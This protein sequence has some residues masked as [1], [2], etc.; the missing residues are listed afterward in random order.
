MA[1]K[2]SEIYSSLWASCDELRGDL[3]DITAHLLGGIPAAD[4]DDLSRYW[5]E[6]AGL[7]DKLFCP[8]ISRIDAKTI[9]ENHLRKFAKIRGPLPTE[10]RKKHFQDLLINR[11]WHSSIY[12]GIYALYKTVSQRISELIVEIAER[13]EQTLPELESA[14]VSDE[15]KVKKHLK[16]MGFVW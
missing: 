10:C 4:V 14:A 3:Q 16:D 7:K 5:G 12:E 9:C 6:F 8:R 2:K 1:I 13:Y 15:T 11:K